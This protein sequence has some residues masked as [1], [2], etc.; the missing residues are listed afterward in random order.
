[1]AIL[2]S[3]KVFEHERNLSTQMPAS[4]SLMMDQG[5]EISPNQLFGGIS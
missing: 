1:M 3:E 2:L 5:L 4:D